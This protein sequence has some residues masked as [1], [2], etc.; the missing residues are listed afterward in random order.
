LFKQAEENLV[1]IG[2]VAGSTVSSVLS[3]TQLG[4]TQRTAQQGLQASA[5]TDAD[6][7][8]DGTTAAASATGTGSS[9]DPSRGT[10]LD[11]SV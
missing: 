10:Q 6:G 8:N 1:A 3:S 7:D 9:G 5:K 11:I 4:G 2:E